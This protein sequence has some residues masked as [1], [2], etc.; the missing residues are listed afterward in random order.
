MKIVILNKKEEQY[1]RDCIIDNYEFIRKRNK[2]SVTDK[3]FKKFNI[4][5]RKIQ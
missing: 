5:E 2:T 3:I 1:V 4:I